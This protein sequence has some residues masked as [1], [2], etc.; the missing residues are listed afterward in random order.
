MLSFARIP[1]LT[2]QL[3][4]S[5]NPSVLAHHFCRLFGPHAIVPGV[6]VVCTATH[7]SALHPILASKHIFGEIIRLP[8]PNKEA[9]QDVS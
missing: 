6:L 4:N 8:M 7:S 3:S 1:E 2:F 5:I 9:R